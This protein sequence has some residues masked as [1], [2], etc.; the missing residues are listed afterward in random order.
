MHYNILKLV[1]SGQGYLETKFIMNKQGDTA[2]YEHHD[3]EYGV[4]LHL[5]CSVMI[6]TFTETF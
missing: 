6:F 2:S 3:P 5:R 4:A 1:K